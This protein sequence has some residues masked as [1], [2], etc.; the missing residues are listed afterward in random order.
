MSPKYAL[1][2]EHIVEVSWKTVSSQMWIPY[3]IYIHIR[4]YDIYIFIYIY[5]LYISA[6]VSG[7]K[8]YFL[9]IQGLHG[10]LCY[11]Y[12]YIYIYIYIYTY[13]YIYKT[14]YLV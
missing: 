8:W 11:T 9:N 5:M 10:I 1:E 13:I 3:I 7:C 6:H 14:L 4:R 12:I 2:D